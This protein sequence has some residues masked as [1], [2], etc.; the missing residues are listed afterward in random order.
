M[1]T[2]KVVRVIAYHRFRFGRWEAVGA[3]WR[4]LPN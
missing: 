4:S 2:S 3:H 1:N